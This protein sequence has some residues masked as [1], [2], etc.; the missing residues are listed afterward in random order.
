MK[1][2]EWQFLSVAIGSRENEQ[3]QEEF[4]SNAD[5][6]S[7]VSGLVRESIQN[8]LDEV[9]DPTKPTRMVFTVGRQSPEITDSYFKDLYPHARKSLKIDPELT[10][11]ESKFL[12]IEDFN[13][14]GLEG[15]TS[16]NAPLE[17]EAS[18]KI[19]KFKNS[20]WFFEWKTGGS[21][22]ASGSRGSWGVGKIVFPRASAIK[23]Y[24]V[25]SVRRHEAAPDGGT[26][27]LFG[28]S[29]LKFREINGTRYVP[30]SQWMT[31][32]EVGMPL[33]SSDLAIQTK[34][35]K[36]WNLTRGL[37]E[38]GTSIVIPF[39]SETI[40]GE[41]LIQSIIRD[42][43]VT[44]LSGR[45][46]CQ[47]QDESGA[48]VSI[49]RESIANLIEEYLDDEH[50]QGSKT[51]TEMKLIC[52]M[53]LKHL[54]GNTNRFTI[55]INPANP[56]DWTAVSLEESLQ[57]QMASDFENGETIEL[58]IET[59]V[60]QVKAD[61]LTSAEDNFVVLLQKVADQKSASVFCREGILIPA[62]NTASIMN[63][64]SMVIVGNLDSP[65]ENENSLANL[66]KFAEGPSHES[67]SA[68]ASK[69][70]GRYTP[71]KMGEST[72]R[73]VK[74][75]VSKILRLIQSQEDEQDDTIL[76]NYFPDTDDGKDRGQ[77]RVI[78]SGRR[79]P[80][81]HS[82]AVLG[83][84]IENFS[85]SSYELVQLSPTRQTLA[86]DSGLAT[87]ATVPLGVQNVEHRFQ[88]KAIDSN[89]TLVSNV[90]VVRPIR[91]TLPPSSP[92]VR[93]DK[94]SNGFSICS[95]ELR[96]LH[97]GQSFGV[98]AGYRR[99]GSDKIQWTLEDFL[100]SS[101]FLPT[102]MKGL[103][104]IDSKENW[105]IFEVVDTDFY[106]EWEGFDLLRDL[107]IEIAIGKQ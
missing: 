87:T 89:Q 22:K 103:R 73:W 71:V 13:T 54:S 3:T 92:K 7:E 43:F 78:L 21:P 51:K 39:A 12:I 4:F 16:S 69:F 28:H 9:L 76:S 81:D 82:L 65:G 77:A 45:L 20:F 42:Y 95:D 62:A 85:P 102:Q 83:W 47:V 37:E 99:R 67:W 88:V 97:I 68:N 80:S 23:S 98:R 8:S 60:P 33:P 2:P 93:I 101:C 41:K 48:F 91:T 44:I 96:P 30:D 17:D 56:N 36:D 66:L 53:Y 61:G 105:G 52:E 27:I 79:N 63:C 64:V 50:N 18:Q 31:V 49:T 106:S 5:V 86:L 104:M 11:T 94:T 57:N 59:H 72:I 14:L 90:L 75:S 29:I 40:S 19:Q 24:L 6:V 25:F 1:A 70:K 38:L 55:P 26:S 15:S 58:R 100:L 10:N 46:E 107:S 84:K 32:N 74:Q 34:F 35:L